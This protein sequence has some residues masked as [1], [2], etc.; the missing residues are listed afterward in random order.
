MLRRVNSEIAFIGAAP[1]QRVSASSTFLVIR[2][3]AADYFPFDHAVFGCIAIRI[4]NEVRRDNRVTY[5]I[6][7]RQELDTPE[8]L[9]RNL[10]M[11]R[12]PRRPKGGRSS[13]LS[14]PTGTYAPPHLGS[15]AFG[16]PFGSAPFGGG[17]PAP[18]RKHAPETVPPP[19]AGTVPI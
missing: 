12:K 5:D 16:T 17:A 14:D 13:T 6:M 7:P 18:E 2:I 8:T 11:A 1:Y 4:I 3:R 9:A 10:R 19:S 15:G